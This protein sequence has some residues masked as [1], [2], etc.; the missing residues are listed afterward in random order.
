MESL[1]NGTSFHAQVAQVLL[2]LHDAQLFLEGPGGAV[3]RSGASS[4]RNMV[5]FSLGT[6]MLLLLGA[7]DIDTW[8]A[9]PLRSLSSTTRY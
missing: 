9:S 5:S 1:E 7:K 3:H 2:L 8:L 4:V 6:S